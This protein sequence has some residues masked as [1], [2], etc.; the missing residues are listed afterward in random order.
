MLSF[1]IDKLNSALSK[2]IS[3]LA[4][5]KRVCALF[6][7]GLDSS[8]LAFLISKCTSVTLY[9]TGIETAY[10]IN[11]ARK[12]AQLL[13]LPIIEIFLT[14]K[15]IENA[16]PV[17]IKITS[18]KNPVEISYLLPLFFVAKHSREKELFS[19]YGADEL[20]AGYSKYLKAENLE[21]ELKKD[22]MCLRE[23]GMICAKKIVSHFNKELKV[24]FLERDIVELGLKIPAEYK[25]KNGVRKYVLREFGRALG[26]PEEIIVREKKA[27]QYGSGTMKV[28]KKLAAKERLSLKEYLEKF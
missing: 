8:I 22:L 21:E 4:D 6:S 3:E 9:V 14:E 10:D 26:L 20:F 1:W 19:A 27:A 28:M 5:K 12:S 13:N 7:G 23:K 25:I 18:F 2:T 11:T 16:I 17:V 24:P 15:D